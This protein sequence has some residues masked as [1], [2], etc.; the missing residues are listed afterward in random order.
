MS[1]ARANEAPAPLLGF[2]MDLP[3]LRDEHVNKAGFYF[4]ATCEDATKSWRG[5]AL[6]ES[7]DPEFGFVKVGDYPLRCRAGIVSTPPLDSSLVNYRLTDYA[8]LITMSMFNPNDELEAVLEAEMYA[9]RNR[10]LIGGEILGAATPALTGTDALSGLG[11][12][13]LS[14]LMRAVK[15]TADA[16]D[17]HVAGECGVW[18]NGP[19]VYFFPQAASRNDEPR[20]YKFVPGG[21]TVAE[22][23]P[24]LLSSSSRTMKPFRPVN[25]SGTRDGSDNLTVKWERQTRYSVQYLEQGQPLGEESERYRFR[26]YLAGTKTLKREEVVTIAPGAARTWSYTASEQLTDGFDPPDP[27]DFEATQLS[28]LV[29]DGNVARFTL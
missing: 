9:G 14:T 22:A 20:Y 10:F 13:D 4:G 3:A 8:S 12:Y 27:I 16:M 29:V 24:F 17:T 28:A 18:L 19:G 2:L 15:D 25:F 23:F 6:F 1:L 7:S 26:A 11:T 5:F 21:G